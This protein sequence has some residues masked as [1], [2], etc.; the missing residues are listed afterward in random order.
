MKVELDAELTAVV[1]T[2]VDKGFAP[3]AEAYIRDL[4]VNDAEQIAHQP[5]I[6]AM[7]RAGLASGFK[8]VGPDYV[9]ELK[10][11]L[12]ARLEEDAA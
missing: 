6:D 8:E 12:A 1:Q 5:E 9:A 2:A 7:L 10:A 3:S 4:I 11:K